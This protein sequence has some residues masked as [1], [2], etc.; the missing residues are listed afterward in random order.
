M[1]Q[2]DIFGMTNLVFSS[3]LGAAIKAL[4]QAL[5]AFEHEKRRHYWL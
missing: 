4:L 2:I 5:S 1:R 3:F